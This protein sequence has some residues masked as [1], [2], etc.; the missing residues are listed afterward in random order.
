[1]ANP[2]VSIGYIL[3]KNV[4]E[5]LLLFCNFKECGRMSKVKSRKSIMDFRPSTF[6][7]F[8]INTLAISTTFKYDNY[9]FEYPIGEEKV[10]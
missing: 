6:N 2:R 3:Y 8:F 10:T 9:N 7:H 5:G 1:M 4:S